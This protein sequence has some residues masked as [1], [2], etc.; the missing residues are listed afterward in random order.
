MKSLEVPRSAIPEKGVAINT[1]AAVEELRPEGAAEVPLRAVTVT[2]TLTASGDECFFRG[3]ISGTFTRACDRCLELAARPFDVDVL[4]CFVKG[5]QPSQREQVLGDG[6]GEVQ[7][8]AERSVFDGNIV[9]LAPQ[10]WEEVALGVPTKFLCREDCAGLCPQCGA[11][12]NNQ[13]CG[14]VQEDEEQDIT[15]NKG[16]AGLKDLFPD[17]KPD[18]SEE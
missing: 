11:N 6:P 8:A 13:T 9:N 2:G 18:D 14:C 7:D 4:W 12:L 10:I 3:Q 17:L 1:V 15:K 16:L 5:L